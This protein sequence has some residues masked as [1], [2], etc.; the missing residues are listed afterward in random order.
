MSNRIWTVVSYVFHPL[1]M[2]TLGTFLIM[3]NDPVVFLALDDPAQWIRILGTLFICTLLFPLV[4]SGILLKVGHVTSLQNADDRERKLLLAF[5]EMGFLWAFLTLHDIPSAGHS[6]Y[7]FILG[8]N[9]A[10]IT[11]LIINF[12]QRTSFHATGAGGLLGAT[13][14]LMYYTRADLKYWIIGVILLCYLVGYARYRLKAHSSFEIYIGY[15]VG[16][17]SLFAVF[18]FGVRQ[19]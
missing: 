10:M 17:V 12:F 11:T 19:V 4:T 3:R 9:I 18:F 6:I 13:I 1:F 16:I 8:I 15:I 2:P 5:S 14:G 7:L